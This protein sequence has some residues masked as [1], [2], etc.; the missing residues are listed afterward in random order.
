MVTI[1]LT[2]KTYNRH[3]KGGG[4]QHDYIFFNFQI[5]FILKTKIR[6]ISLSL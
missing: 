6:N 1:L 5:D 2:S 4:S 3:N